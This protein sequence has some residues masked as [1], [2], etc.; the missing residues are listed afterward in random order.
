MPFDFQNKFEQ[1]YLR[2]DARLSDFC[3]TQLANAVRNLC[4]MSGAID[5]EISAP[6]T[7]H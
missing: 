3:L 1:L 2:L 6:R 5:S 4:S 7:I